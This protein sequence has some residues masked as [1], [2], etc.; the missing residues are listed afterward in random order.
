[1]GSGGYILLK[2]KDAGAVLIGAGVSMTAI[3]QIEE[4]K[5]KERL[6]RQNRNNELFDYRFG[7]LLEQNW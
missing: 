5:Q 3:Q 2:G 7:E 4:H 6:D 1:M